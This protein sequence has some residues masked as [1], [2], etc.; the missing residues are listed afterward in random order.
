MAAGT[1]HYL[2]GVLQ[3][4]DVLECISEI[5]FPKSVLSVQLADKGDSVFTICDT[6]PFYQSQSCQFKQWLES[7]KHIKQH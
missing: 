3:E 6:S 7:F 4:D 5:G 1:D 2:R